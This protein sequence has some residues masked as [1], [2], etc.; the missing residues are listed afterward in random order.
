[1]IKFSDITLENCV[2]VA[3][4][5]PNEAVKIAQAFP[6]KAPLIASLTSKE[7]ALEVVKA[8]PEQLERI[9]SECR[10]DRE[11]IIAIVQGFPEKAPEIALTTSSIFRQIE[12]VELYPEK[13]V[14]IAKACH[15]YSERITNGD[16]SYY[17]PM[18][19]LLAALYPEKASEIESGIDSKEFNEICFLDLYSKNPKEKDFLISVIVAHP[20]FVDLLITRF[21]SIGKDILKASSSIKDRWKL[22][23]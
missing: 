18:I 17:L 23:D 16:Y 7:G 9:I 6:E 2:L 22:E 5:N 8:C 15:N 1:M 13:I 4:A 20:K 19:S 14:E 3:I 11:K 10:G 21:P 12:I